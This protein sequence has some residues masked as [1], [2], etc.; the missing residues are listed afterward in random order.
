VSHY[1]RAGTAGLAIVLVI[2]MLIEREDLRNRLFGLFGDGRLAVT[3]KALDEEGR[4]GREH[5][6]DRVEQLPHEVA[7]NGNAEIVQSPDRG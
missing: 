2:F 1:P 4:P 5:P 6:V 7:R 3:T